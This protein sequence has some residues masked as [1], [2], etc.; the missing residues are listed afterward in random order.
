MVLTKHG[1]MIFK[2]LEKLRPGIPA[3][4]EIEERVNEVLY[5]QKMQ[6]ALRKYLVTLR[7]ESYIYLAPGYV[8]AGAERPS[9]AVLAKKG[10]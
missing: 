9:E 8:D 7:K 6:P 4:E 5:N 1:Y 2:V 10:E 3:F